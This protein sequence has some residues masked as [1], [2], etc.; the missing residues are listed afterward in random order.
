MVSP[1]RFT[2]C[3]QTLNYQ[4]LSPET[5]GLNQTQNYEW[6]F[7]TEAGEN[8]KGCGKW[9]EESQAKT[10][11]LHLGVSGVT[12]FKIVERQFQCRPWRRSLKAMP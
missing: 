9:E 3:C 10:K 11:D 8:E 12:R 2:I 5:G 6:N 7:D 4:G 1:G